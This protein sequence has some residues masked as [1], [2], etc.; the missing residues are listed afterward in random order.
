M[1][2]RSLVRLLCSCCHCWRC[3]L[4]CVVA[5][6]CA[7][8]CKFAGH[9]E[10]AKVKTTDDG[11]SR[12]WGIVEFRDAADAAT[13]IREFVPPL[14]ELSLSLSTSLSRF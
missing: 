2:T 1:P 4:R 12:G 5:L 11:L 10:F 13:A 6:T 14:V 9:V 3:V 7:S 8:L